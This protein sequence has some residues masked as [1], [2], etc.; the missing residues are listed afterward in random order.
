MTD[1][2]IKVYSRTIPR[3]GN[4]M[5]RFPLCGPFTRR[6]EVDFEVFSNY[7]LS[8]ECFMMRKILWMT[9]AG[10]QDWGRVGEIGRTDHQAV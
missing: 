4:A 8:P 5:L 6:H 1:N 7:S 10:F 3:S 9:E 2:A